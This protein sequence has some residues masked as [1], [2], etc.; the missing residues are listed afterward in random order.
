MFYFSRTLPQRTQEGL[1]FR[2]L[3]SLLSFALLPPVAGRPNVVELASGHVGFTQPPALAMEA[4]EVRP[5]EVFAPAAPARGLA[6]ADELGQ[7]D[8]GEFV[9][10][11]HLR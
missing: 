1:G 4:V 5:V 2:V 6:A 10:S 9:I 8:A 11:V 7:D 3:V